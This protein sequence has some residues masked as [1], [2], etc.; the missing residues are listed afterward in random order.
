MSC[1]L[2]C[3]RC[4]LYFL[5]VLYITSGL[6]MIVVASL[7][8]TGTSSL[9]E[10]IDYR[11]EIKPIFQGIY[12]MIS[13]GVG[14]FLL[15]FIGCAAAVR[16][17]RYGLWLFLFLTVIIMVLQWI[18]A[19]VTFVNY[20]EGK[21]FIKNTMDIYSNEEILSPCLEIEDDNKRDLCFHQKKYKAEKS[22]WAEVLMNERWQ[23][24]TEQ[25]EML[26]EIASPMVSVVWEKIQKENQCCG[27]VGQSDWIDSDFQKIPATCCNSDNLTNRTEIARNNRPV[28]RHYCS[29]GASNFV[30]CEEKA[31]KYANL[32][33]I[34]FFYC[35]ITEL[36]GI[37]VTSVYIKQLKEARS[38]KIIQEKM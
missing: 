25:T 35:F 29:K 27:L 6:L 3:T 14:L 5:N 2:S 24:N 15:G 7:V 31:L 18:G 37:I 16:Q 28:L 10:F 38:P 19:I 4:F 30:G 17:N 12:M 11:P 21:K 20:P 1:K 23:T 26:F 22:G 33:G 36:L 13:A 8:I 9:R 34:A 32:T